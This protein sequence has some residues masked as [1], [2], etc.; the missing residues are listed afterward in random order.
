MRRTSVPTQLKRWVAWANLFA[1][2]YPIADT[3]KLWLAHATHYITCVGAFG[4]GG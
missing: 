3:G 4:G 1:R 2:V